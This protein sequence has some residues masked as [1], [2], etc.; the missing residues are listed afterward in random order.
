M[1]KDTT[2]VP[3]VLKRHFL[4]FDDLDIYEMVGQ[5]LQEA[6]E[7]SEGFMTRCPD[8]KSRM[9]IEVKKEFIGQLEKFTLDGQKIRF[10]IMTKTGDDGLKFEELVSFKAL[11]QTRVSTSVYGIIKGSSLL[12]KQYRHRRQHAPF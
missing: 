2:T 12:R 10:L 8:G 6:G 5:G 4:A 1:N 7:S 9:S 11:K 3:K